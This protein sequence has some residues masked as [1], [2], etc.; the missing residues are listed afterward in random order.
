MGKDAGKN[1]LVAGPRSE[2]G[3]REVRADVNLISVAEL[4]T[5]MRVTAKTHYRQRAQA[6]G[7]GCGGRPAGGS[8]R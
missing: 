4:D 3:V 7:G 5:P 2:L 6:A 1:V 8:F